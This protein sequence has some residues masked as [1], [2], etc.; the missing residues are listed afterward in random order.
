MVQREVKWT[1]RAIKDKLSIYE[2][3]TE[4]NKSIDYPRKLETIFNEAAYLTSLFPFSGHNSNLRDV[5][6]R[7]IRNYRLYYR[8]NSDTI[9]ILSVWDTNRD[10]IE[11]D[12]K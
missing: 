9:E 8:I 7:V 1:I 12:L 3:W 2:Y 10:P 11:D 4:R 6:F 5:R